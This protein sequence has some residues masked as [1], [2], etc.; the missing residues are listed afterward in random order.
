MTDKEISEYLF[1][2]DQNQSGDIA[3]VFG[4]EYWNNP[5]EKAVE[6][7]KKGL[8]KKILFTGG[9]NRLSGKE[10]GVSMYQ[11]A[12]EK[13]I[14][15][16]DLFMEDKAANT[17]ENVIFSR[18]LLEEKDILK[19]IQVVC[20]VMVNAHARRVLM[21]FKKNFPSEIIIKACPYVYAPYDWAKD[22]WV[23]NPKARELVESEM[24]KIE[25]Y[26]AKGDIAE[27]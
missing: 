15:E 24:L 7:Y 16:E 2:E 27:L 20:A 14:P 6:L 8:V 17:L 4:I 3:I 9:V 25:T 22:N 19:D 12:L 21:T 11:G 13:G 1:L 26:V 23:N 5:L 10:E 18:K